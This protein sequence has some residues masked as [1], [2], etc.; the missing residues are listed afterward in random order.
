VEQYLGQAMFLLD[1]GALPQQV[2][3]A[4]EKWGMAM[5][6]FR[7]SDLAGL[8]VGWYIRKR[9]YVEYPD[10]VYSKIADRICELGRFGQKTGAGFY[11]YEP[12]RRE[13]LP[14]PKIEELIVG[15]SKEIGVAR[16]AISDEEI[17]QRCIYAL[18]NEAA[19]ILEEGIALRASDIDLVYINGYGFP[20]Y[21]G[22]PMFYADAVGL[23][24]VV[25]A[26]EKFRAGRHGESWVPAP[27]LAKLAAEGGRFSQA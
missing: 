8:D 2:D 17:I 9:R 12:G 10:M 13:A 15:Y 5:G 14:D 20:P 24:S 22:G 3:Q 19:H 27:L 16:R 18:V 7:M 26:M 25:A 1:E 21:R 4:L 23:R 6:P 11:R